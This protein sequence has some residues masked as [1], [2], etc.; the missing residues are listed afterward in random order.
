MTNFEKFKFP[1]DY[2]SFYK[3]VPLSDKQIN[4]FIQ[5]GI[6]SLREK[7]VH[8]DETPS[9][10]CATGNVLVTMFAYK[11]GNGKYTLYVNV[12]KGYFQESAI[13]VEF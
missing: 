5:S 11:Q 13:D 10:S 8:G 1:G 4:N 9:Y 7:I 3:G 12:S 2:F 6:E